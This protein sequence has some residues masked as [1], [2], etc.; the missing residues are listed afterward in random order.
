M[1]HKV[2]IFEFEDDLCAALN[3]TDFR[4]FDVCEIMDVF[5]SRLTR[6]YYEVLW[7]FFKQKYVLNEKVAQF[8]QMK[9]FQDGYIRLR[10]FKM[11]FYFRKWKHI[12]KYQSESSVLSE[13]SRALSEI[14]SIK[15]EPSESWVDFIT[16]LVKTDKKK[17][18]QKLSVVYTYSKYMNIWR[19]KL[20]AK[21]KEKFK[22]WK[23]LMDICHKDTIIKGKIFDAN[24]KWKIFA[25]KLKIMHTQQECSKY[26][27]IKMFIDLVNKYVEYNIE[28]EQK[29]H[30]E[31]L[32]QRM[33]SLWLAKFS[34]ISSIDN[35]LTLELI[36]PSGINEE[37]EQFVDVPSADNFKVISSVVCSQRRQKLKKSQK[38]YDF[39][40]PNDISISTLDP[41]ANF[42]SK[43][44]IPEIHQQNSPKRK[45]QRKVS[46]ETDDSQQSQSESSRTKGK[47]K[48][49][50]ISR[51]IESSPQSMK[52]GKS[53]SSI[54]EDLC[55]P[56][57][58]IP[59][60]IFTASPLIKKRKKHYE[61]QPFCSTAK[62]QPPPLPVPGIKK[63]KKKKQNKIDFEFDEIQQ[64]LE[65]EIFNIIEFHI[66][67]STNS[68]FSL[69][70]LHND[71]SII[72]EVVENQKKKKRSKTP[73]GNKKKQFIPI[74]E[75]PH[76]ASLIE[77]DEYAATLDPSPVMKLRKAHK[78]KHKSQNDDISTT[79]DE[80]TPRRKKKVKKHASTLDE[81]TTQ[82]L[83]ETSTKNESSLIGDETSSQKN[84]ESFTS[85][86][87]RTKKVSFNNEEISRLK[88]EFASLQ[89]AQNNNESV[90]EEKV[91][92]QKNNEETPQ[93]KQN[94]E[95]YNE[96]T[97]ISLDHKEDSQNNDQQVIVREEEISLSTDDLSNKK[98]ETSQTT[99][100]SVNEGEITKK[101]HRK[102]KSQSNE[103]N[104]TEPEITVE[105]DVPK[106]EEPPKK[107]KRKA[108]SQKTESSLDLSTTFDNELSQL[109]QS[110]SATIEEDVSK[111]E[112]LPKK[113]KRKAHSQ[114]ADSSSLDLSTTLDE[115]SQLS[116]IK[117]VIVEEDVSKLE[118][119][120]KKKKRKAHSQKADSSLDLSVTLDEMS[121][122]IST[123]DEITPK[124]KHRNHKTDLD[125]NLLDKLFSQA[126]NET[127]CDSINYD[128]DAASSLEYVNEPKAKQEFKLDNSNLSVSLDETIKAEI[129]NVIEKSVNAVEINHD[130]DFKSKMH[131]DA[132]SESVKSSKSKKSQNTSEFES[133]SCSA[134]IRKPAIPFVDSLQ[135]FASTN[136]NI[137]DDDDLESIGKMLDQILIDTVNRARPSETIIIEPTIETKDNN[138][139]L[140]LNN[141][142][143]FIEE[144]EEWMQPEKIE[145]VE[146]DNKGGGGIKP[147]RS[148]KELILAPWIHLDEKI[149]ETV[150]EN[151][152]DDCVKS[153]CEVVDFAL[154]EVADCTEFKSIELSP[155]DRIVTDFLF[156]SFESTILSTAATAAVTN[157]DTIKR[158]VYKKHHKGNTSFNYSSFISANNENEFVASD[159][160]DYFSGIVEDLV[161]HSFSQLRNTTIAIKGEVLNKLQ[162]VEEKSTDEDEKGGIKPSRSVKELFLPKFDGKKPEQDETEEEEEEE[163]T[164]NEDKT[165]GGG[166]KPARNV[167]ELFLQ[168]LDEKMREKNETEDK[169]D[170]TTNEEE[171]GGGG[172]KP[173]RSVK[174]IFLQTSNEKI[175]DDDD[176]E[177][178][179]EH[180]ENEK[181]EDQED[182][183]V[184]EKH[185][186]Q[187]I[188]KE[189]VDDKK[190]EQENHH[191]EIVDKKHD[192]NQKDEKDEEKHER[193]G[194]IKEDVDDKE[195]DGVDHLQE[196]LY[197]S[198]EVVEIG[199]SDEEDEEEERQFKSV[200]DSILLLGVPSTFI[201]IDSQTGEEENENSYNDQESD[202]KSMEEK[203][204]SRDLPSNFEDSLTSPQEKSPIHYPSFMTAK[205]L[206][207]VTFNFAVPRPNS[208]SN[209]P[210]VNPM[211]FDEALFSRS[212]TNAIKE[213]VTITLPDIREIPLEGQIFFHE[214]KER[215][216]QIR[217]YLAKNYIFDP[218]DFDI[219]FAV[220][221]GSVA[222]S[223]IRNILNNLHPQLVPYKDDP[224]QT[225]WRE[226]VPIKVE[227]KASNVSDGFALPDFLGVSPMRNN[228]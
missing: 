38:L 213:V 8:H 3:E 117:S 139:E 95:I 63:G 84:N 211:S 30:D 120:P 174:E 145:I 173:A 155:V 167:N 74:P 25:S 160:P 10:Y 147:T 218:S 144:E 77:E 26:K 108:H 115:L 179:E 21:K 222:A 99:N 176:E 1:L 94:V 22:Q 135:E 100:E 39:E 128:V 40:V 34:Y 41:L 79:L 119:P 197:H 50:I 53:F 2:G 42:T 168:T 73:Q 27:R 12:Y 69:Y 48:P 204:I 184:E 152:L 43:P 86:T 151:L 180:N 110:K 199:L 148:V 97:P 52:S 220:A 58:H 89:T 157:T 72:K 45:K 122:N 80:E 67:S 159:F 14:S 87:S 82:T 208:Y 4:A 126:I 178:E 165:G 214:H 51:D 175:L 11:K 7:K 16:G 90:N 183:K 91:S 71:Q 46:I 130:D 9:L 113:K 196:I 111:I 54:S 29:I 5:K 123:V 219:S 102:H 107:K 93:I 166:I 224:T 149:F 132:D 228:Y 17:P 85:E 134:S 203:V 101:K 116:Q 125:I 154:S 172:I 104:N 136:L 158:I 33:F 83:E 225:F 141:E 137:L 96:E 215:M 223:N 210:K 193:Q 187:G 163:S 161:S 212:L 177:E 75:E 106:S 59:Q 81:S 129:E 98:E 28:K 6:E 60:P 92:P 124:K 221:I 202:S 64:I 78:K 121:Q 200:P 105:E 68:L 49:E 169:E 35:D 190:L 23:T 209:I 37:T 36:L 146:E 61:N 70:K 217:Q 57:L 185:E 47:K 191:N 188:I 44:E 56:V 182:E 227:R 181:Q 206:R 142:E 76:H 65:D 205:G 170:E 156:E 207:H 127:V 138:E 66:N 186:R 226:A 24:E 133:E 192:E 140:M 118:E 150:Y 153:R 162:E 189:N 18:G 62:T 55:T 164:T 143:E 19:N 31:Y 131:K 114:K 109:S 32:M 15:I 194:I 201:M 171:K 216:H 20:L 13:R 103:I 112:E 195:N 88:H 198:Q